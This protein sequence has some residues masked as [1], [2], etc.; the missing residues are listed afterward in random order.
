MTS[1]VKTAGAEIRT[2]ADLLDRLGGIAPDRIRF[3][4]APGTATEADLLATDRA[5][6]VPC[7]LIDGV[8]VE[9]AVSYRE[10]L[11]A[12]L[13]VHL[14]RGF[15]DP[16]N[17]GLVSG[18]DGMMRLFPGLIR[19]PDV[20]FASWGRIPG[21]RVPDEPIAGFAPDLAIEVLSPGNT[22]AEMAR[23]RRDFF[24]AGVRVVWT[25]DP[26]NRTVVVDTRDG[27]TLT[28]RAGDLL[29]GD[30]CLPGFR[31]AL[32]ELFSELDRHAG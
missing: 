21:G 17:L 22:R 29:E 4:P 27:P 30:P 20:A 6:E 31:L 26:K 23:K 13:L 28:L 2:L 15:I 7:E 8:I 32:D 16:R 5:G 11:L 3:H 19:I 14:L 18:A 9:K 25:V 12:S 1:W 24:G 10:S